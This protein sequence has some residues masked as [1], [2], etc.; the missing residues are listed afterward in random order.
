M[1]DTNIECICM[2]CG[3]IHEFSN[4][5]IALELLDGDPRKSMVTN[6][7]CSACGE[8]LVTDDEGETE[9]PGWMRRDDKNSLF[10][11]EKKESPNC[12]P[13]Q[14]VAQNVAGP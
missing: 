1:D 6:C 9:P 7:C 8:A 3:L 5:E 11:V 13:P 2:G 4:D 12:V 10:R 14:Y